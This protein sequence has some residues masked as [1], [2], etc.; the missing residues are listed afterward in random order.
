MKNILK[1]KILIE[2]LYDSRSLSKNK[3]SKPFSRMT[4]EE[5][6]EAYHKIR[7]QKTCTKQNL[8]YRLSFYDYLL[9]NNKLHLIE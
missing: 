2:N 3:L 8:N 5:L 4:D 1:G 6:I 9:K 7:H